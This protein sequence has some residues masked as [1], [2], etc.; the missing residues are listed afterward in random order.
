MEVK[1]HEWV[2]SF[3]LNLVHYIQI[4]EIGN[5]FNIVDTSRDENM[6][7]K[8]CSKIQFNPGLTRM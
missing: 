4:Q 3:F 1:E 7:T 6:W 8:I 5:S 2:L